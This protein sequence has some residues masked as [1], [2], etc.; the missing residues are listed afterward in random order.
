[1]PRDQIQNAQTAS[2]YF[3]QVNDYLKNEFINYGEVGSGIKLLSPEKVTALK[4]RGVEDL[5]TADT[6]ELVYFTKA[7][8]LTTTLPSG[9]KAELNVVNRNQIYDTL[10]WTTTPQNIKKALRSGVFDHWPIQNPLAKMIAQLGTYKKLV[11]NRSVEESYVVKHNVEKLA[12][13]DFTQDCIELLQPLHFSINNYDSS[14]SPRK[15]L[16]SIIKKL[17]TYEIELKKIKESNAL[18]GAFYQNLYASVDP[19][20]ANIKAY[21]A[22]LNV[23]VEQ[24][25]AKIKEISLE[26]MQAILRPYANPF[27]LPDLCLQHFMQIQ[28][29]AILN[30]AV[31]ANYIASGLFQD[32]SGLQKIITETQYISESFSSDDVDYHNP[33][34]PQH[35]F[36]FSEGVEA[37]GLVTLDMRRFGFVPATKVAL[38]KQVALIERI[39]SNGDL[40]KQTDLIRGFFGINWRGNVRAPLTWLTNGAKDIFGTGADVIYLIAKSIYDGVKRAQGQK[41]QPVN[42][43]SGTPSLL[44]T[45]LSENNYASLNANRKLYQVNPVTKIP[46]QSLIQQLYSGAAAIVKR[47]LIEPIVSVS[48]V[49][50][51]E[52]WHLKTLR[53]IWYDATIGLKKV[54]ETTIRLLLNERLNEKRANEAGNEISQQ[55]LIESYIELSGNSLLTPYQDISKTLEERKLKL[56]GTAVIPYHLTPDKPGDFINFVTNDLGRE[57]VQFFSHEVYR[58]HPVAG[59]AFTLAASTAAPMIFPVF[60]HNTTLAAIHKN[61]SVPLA[62]TLIGETSGLVSGV[63]TALLQGK[64]TY[65]ALDIFNGR[66]SLLNYGVKSLLE[67]PVTATVVTAA[68]ISFGYLIAYDLEIP[69]LSEKIAE[70]TAKASFPY[71]E[72]GLTGAKFAA[73]LVEGTLNLHHEQHQLSSEEFVDT[74]IDK[75]RTEIKAAMIKGYCKE[76]HVNRKELTNTDLLKIEQQV[77]NYCEKIKEALKKPHIAEQVSQL[78]FTLGTLIGIKNPPMFNGVPPRVSNPASQKELALFLQRREIRHQ[79]AEL[80]PKHLTEKNKYV[81]LNYLAQT[82]PADQ[83]YIASVRTRFE[84]EKKVG[85]IGE[86]L[87]IVVSYPGAIIRTLIALIRSSIYSGRALYYARR[88]NSRHYRVMLETSR[89]AI[90]PVTDFG[91]KI[92]NDFG[93]IVKGFTA[94]FRNLWGLIGG[95]LQLPMTIVLAAPVAI[96]SSRLSVRMFARIN[97]TL[98]APGLLSKLIDFSVGVMRV[99]A[100]SKDILLVTQDID[101][102]Y[103]RKILN[104]AYSKT[105]VTAEEPAKPLSATDKDNKVKALLTN[106]LEKHASLRMLLANKP[107]TLLKLIENI[108][109]ESAKG[110]RHKFYFFTT[111]KEQFNQDLRKALLKVHAQIAELNDFTFKDQLQHQLMIMNLFYGNKNDPVSEFIISYEGFK[112]VNLPEPPVHKDLLKIY[113]TLKD[114]QM[115]VLALK[116]SYNENSEL[117]RTQEIVRLIRDNDCLSIHTVRQIARLQTIIQTMTDEAQAL[118]KDKPTQTSIDLAKAKKMLLALSFAHQSARIAAHRLAGNK[119]VFR[120]LTELHKPEVVDKLSVGKRNLTFGKPTS[121]QVQ[122][123]ATEHMP[124]QR[125]SSH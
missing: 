111:P 7:S 106:A 99:D 96:F 26:E 74:A 100:G 57:L 104:P 13:V 16:L 35:A 98:F 61:I 47:Y 8:I 31:E 119:K 37:G 2:Q 46:H 49:I 38:A 60:M 85:P 103:N 32:S 86:T 67:N 91:R 65:L 69:Y 33:I 42:F 75:M 56:P 107:K 41:P 105:A 120:A 20:V 121:P 14:V 66:N 71:F 19:L 51:D 88:E 93:L 115:A 78:T 29:N 81:I 82:Y 73:I 39:D 118:P 15:N 18:T 58:G 72:L 113:A 95:F 101:I 70:E 4:G 30:N 110:D 11:F 83:D 27:N 94:M 124:K 34:S 25:N 102:R 125:K 54:D 84:Q 36:E 22:S 21:K 5:A 43:P 117:S 3:E 63:S 64:I 9:K 28:L 79:I 48:H 76:H 108:K 10:V 24:A 123:T 97:R 62:Q 53:K 50:A 55:A 23:R 77:R 114:A 17:E 59:L 6:A 116:V 68:A 89:H 12:I 92:K 109:I 87:K 90:I 45:D 44:K 40:Y 52:L 112:G 1:M 122:P 80:D